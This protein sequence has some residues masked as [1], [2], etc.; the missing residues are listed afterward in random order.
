MF[1]LDIYWAIRSVYNEIYASELYEE[2][3]KFISFVLN[4]KSI[5]E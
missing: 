4:K 5:L 2:S 1:L 3:L